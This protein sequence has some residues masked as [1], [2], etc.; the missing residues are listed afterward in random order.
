ML[1]GQRLHRLFEEARYQHLHAI[2]VKADQ[3]P[4]EGDRQ[5][6]LAFLVFLLKDDLRQHR[7]R[8]VFARLGV[9]HDEILAALDHD[10]QVLKRD[11]GAG[12]GIVETPVGVFLDCDRLFFV[13]H[14]DHVPPAQG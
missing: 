6:A 4:Q 8:D 3:L 11:V 9:E 12:P 10:S 14:V 13:C 2:A 7:A 1:A 5:Q